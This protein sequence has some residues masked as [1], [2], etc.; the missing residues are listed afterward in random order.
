MFT[1]FA[2]MLFDG[3]LSEVL[4]AHRHLTDRL[5]GAALSAVLLIS[6]LLAI[7]VVT[8]APFAATFFRE[9]QL[10]AILQVSA[11]YLPL[12]ALGFAPTV[13]LTKQMRFKQLGLI[14]LASGAL[15][16]LA[17]LALAYSGAAYWALI[18]GNFLGMSIRVALLWLTTN[19]R[20]TPNLHWKELQPVLRNGTH[21]IGQ[22]L[23]YFGIDNLD[24]FLLSRFSGPIQLGPY[25]VAR[26]LAH[27]ALDKISR[28]TGQV[29]VPT[30][31]AT[32]ATDEQLRGLLT[33]ISVSATVAFPLF[34]IMAITSQVALPMLFG[35][36]WLHMIIPFA[37]FS[38]VLPLRTIYSFL[39]SSLVGTGRTAVTFKNTLTW[40]AL[41]FPFVLIGVTKGAVGVAI[42][43]TA[44]FPF[45]FYFA[46]QRTSKA[47]RIKISA[48]LK[49][50]V[51]PIICAGLSVI[52]AEAVLL[53]LTNHVRAPIIFVL[54]CLVATT[55]YV[56]L[57]RQISR[58]QYEHTLSLVQRVSRI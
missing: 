11:F 27:T 12:T 45:V 44:A 50:I 34:W 13:H 9:R 25:S 51:P 31:A 21:M 47:F 38:A 36:R 5:Q 35:H 1:V 16:G 8:I 52:S 53:G 56:T 4:V 30:F 23:S 3:G 28:V 6:S 7:L 54:Q 55:C 17:T 39:N 37:S 49:P 24:V 20:P 57:L 10:L 29:A 26:T 48:L 14:Q 15:Q 22:R 32:T 41:L 33:I 18:I 2:Q 58:T 40:L 42:G 43:W 19:E 46:M